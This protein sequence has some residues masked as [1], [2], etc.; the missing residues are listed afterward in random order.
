MIL[1][2]PIASNQKAAH[3]QSLPCLLLIMVACFGIGVIV[4]QLSGTGGSFTISPPT[5]TSLLL[6]NTNDGTSTAPSTTTETTTKTAILS[7]TTSASPNKTTSLSPLL[8]P[9]PQRLLSERFQECDNG[10]KIS[11]TGGFCLTQ[12]NTIGGNHMFDRPL[13]M[14]LANHVFKDQSVVDLGAGLG[15]YGRIFNE[16]NAPVKSWR[17]FDGALNVQTVTNGLV[18]FMDLTQPHATD[19]RPCVQGDWVLSLEVAEHIPVKYTDAYLRNVRCHARYG[20]VISWARPEQTGGLG[21]VN[22]KTEGE[23]IVA[24]EQW[25]FRVDWEL[26]RGA[27]AAATISHFEKTPVVYRVVN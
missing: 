16:P 17:G 7:S 12:V 18:R 10:R 27:R 26:T 19:E 21:H 13:A 3:S 5:T 1:S 4:G 9:I 24:V 2:K 22:T 6:R 20:A 25:G 8:L 11:T 23:A 14:Y 15:H